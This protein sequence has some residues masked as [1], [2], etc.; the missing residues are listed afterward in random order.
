MDKQ[1]S[2]RDWCRDDAP[3]LD[4]TA[5]EVIQGLCEEVDDVRKQLAAK[6]TEIEWL[7]EQKRVLAQS[8]AI[9]D[10]LGAILV[11]DHRN[12]R[13]LFSEMAALKNARVSEWLRG[14]ERTDV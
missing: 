2:M 13:Y 6:N 10:A 11:H 1:T 7:I 4:V 14:L 9:L 12:R 3:L 5:E 8:A